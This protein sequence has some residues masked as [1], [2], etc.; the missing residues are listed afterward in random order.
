VHSAIS[1][2]LERVALGLGLACKVPIKL[3]V[4]LDLNQL[5][6][7]LHT[8]DTTL[9]KGR[10]VMHACRYAESVDLTFPSRSHTFRST[11]TSPAFILTR[12]QATSIEHP[13]G[14]LLQCSPSSS[15]PFCYHQ[16]PHPTRDP[17][18]AVPPGSANPVPPSCRRPPHHRYTSTA[19]TALAILSDDTFDI[20]V[21]Q[22]RKDR[23]R[24]K[25]PITS[26]IRNTRDP[27]PSLLVIT[28][29][30]S[31]LNNP[32]IAATPL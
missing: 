5:I 30:S 15:P 9:L 13:L 19:S 32:L 7:R 31:R 20:S 11:T 3:H 12:G 8:F 6:T 14:P 4:I 23:I 25:V 29:S 28:T 21:S 24:R 26:L 22:T 1:V 16:H 2:T 10:S 17:I 18:P 27:Y